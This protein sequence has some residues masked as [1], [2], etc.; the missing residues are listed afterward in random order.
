MKHHNP[1]SVLSLLTAFMA[2]PSLGIAGRS[3]RSYFGL[4]AVFAGVMTH[5]VASLGSKPN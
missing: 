2:E 5:L 3:W 1:L 4:I